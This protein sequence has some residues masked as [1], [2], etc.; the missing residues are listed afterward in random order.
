MIIPERWNKR[1]NQLMRGADDEELCVSV[2]R[3]YYR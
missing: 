1:K 2:M 3:K